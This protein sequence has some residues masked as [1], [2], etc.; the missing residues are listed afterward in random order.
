MSIFEIQEGEQDNTTPEQLAQL[1]LLARNYQKKCVDQGWHK[2]EPAAVSPLSMCLQKLCFEYIERFHTQRRS[3]MSAVLDAELWKASEV[4]EEIQCLVDE[5]IR[6]N[7]LRNVTIPS[8]ST[9]A[10][11]SLM[12]A[13]SAYVVAKSALV[14]I[15]ILADYCECFVALPEFAADILSRVVE[16][17]KGFNSRCCQL[18]LGAGA[19]QLVGL[20]TISVRNLALAS[21]SLQLIVHI[22]PLVTKEAE[23]AL[24]DDQVHLLRHIKQWEVSSSVPSPSFQQICRQ[25]QKFHNGLSGIIPD[26]QV[27]VLLLF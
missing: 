16:L 21:R 27:K 10:R 23:L 7:R 9:T 26:E 24:K 4:N 13:N 6:T 17:L 12:V 20:K 8:P 22:V 19:L 25:M 2:A 18:I 5:S 11:M 15:K 1:I 14:F 3:R